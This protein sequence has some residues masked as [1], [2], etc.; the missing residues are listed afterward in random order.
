MK[1]LIF[2]IVDKK[3]IKSLL[4]TMFIDLLVKQGK[5]DKPSI[6]RI[7]SCQKVVM[8]YADNLLVGIGAIKPKTISDFNKKKADLENVE[9]NFEWEL[10]YFFVDNNYRGYGI[11]TMM[12]RLLLLGKDNENIMASTELYRSNAMINVLEKFGF[13]QFGKPWTSKKHD[14]TI[15]LFLK[16]KPG[17]VKDSKSASKK[18]LFT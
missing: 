7:Q 9:K 2:K 12:A 13:R 18:N 6:T 11:S 16:F 4:A 15:G 17:E 1:E 5:V 10:G 8:C 14:G 3:N